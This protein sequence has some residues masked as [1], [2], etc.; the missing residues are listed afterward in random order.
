[1]APAGYSLIFED[2]FSSLDGWKVTSPEQFRGYGQEI[3]DASHVAIVNGQLALGATPDMHSGEVR[4]I[5]KFGFGYYEC[6]MKLPKTPGF[7]PA[8]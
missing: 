4:S 7:W 5:S 1:M 8:F 2:G 3:W 6:R